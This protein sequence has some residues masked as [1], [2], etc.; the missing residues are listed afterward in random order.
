MGLVALN[1]L[2]T[3]EIP[4]PVVI[5]SQAQWLTSLMP[6]LGRLQ[7]KHEFQASLGYEDFVF[8]KE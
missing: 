4:F 5:E 2:L 3:Y 7:E 8:S 1:T 6:A